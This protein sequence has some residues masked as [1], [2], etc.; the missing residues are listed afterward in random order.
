MARNKRQDDKYNSP[1]A[2]VL[3]DLLIERGKTQG[4]IANITGKTR[5]TVSQYCNGASEPGYDTLVKIADYFNVSLDYLL[6]RTEDPSQHPC[7]ANELGLTQKSIGVLSLAQKVVG[8]YY[9]AKHIDTLSEDAEILFSMM[10]ENGYV[11]RWLSLRIGEEYLSPDETVDLIFCYANELQ[12]FVD[13]MISVVCENGSILFDFDN[14]RSVHKQED[15]KDA[16]A[17]AITVASF[18]GTGRVRA[19]TNK[20]YVRYISNEIAKAIDQYLVERYEHGID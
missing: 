2:T 4:D 17:L 7:A 15:N 13:T 5:Q 18:P 8:E 20:E 16:D 10:K 3:R 1:F 6:G 12:R 19:L 9:H 14:Y 11:E